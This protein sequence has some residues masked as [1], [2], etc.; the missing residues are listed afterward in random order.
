MSFFMIIFILAEQN[1]NFNYAIFV[2]FL[3]APFN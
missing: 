2:Y 3:L 1:V